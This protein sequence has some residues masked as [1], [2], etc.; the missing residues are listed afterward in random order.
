MG[1]KGASHH[2]SMNIKDYTSL[3][4]EKSKEKCKNYGTFEVIK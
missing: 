4:K 3:I 2:S 1:N